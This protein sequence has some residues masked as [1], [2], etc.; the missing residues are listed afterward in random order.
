MIKEE[1]LLLSKMSYTSKDF[2]A[3]YTDLLD[4]A[5]QLT[6]KWDPSLSNESDPGVV[7]LKEG[8]FIADHG[9]YNIDKNVLE[10][11]L[12]SATQDTSA[13]NILE[14]NGYTPEYYISASG[15]VNLTYQ[16][17]TI[18]EN[19][20]GFT[21][22][23]FT[24]VITNAD[25]SIF[26]TQV[27]SI[28]IS[29]IGLASTA[30]FMQG[31]KQSLAINGS[32]TI[33]L[34]NLD[35]NNRVYLPVKQ[36]AE[37]GIFIKNVVTTAQDDGE[38][39]VKN[40]YISTQPLNSKVY[41]VGYDSA[42]GVPYIEFPSDI[43]NIIGS[44]LTID[45]IT[46]DGD[47]GN[48]KANT[49]IQI[50]SPTTLTIEETGLEID[51]TKDFN[52]TN[53]TSIMNGKNPETINEM[54]R[55]FK[56]V[57]GTFD[58]LVTCKDYSNAIFN[59]TESNSTNK[60]VS[61]DVVTDRNS[62]FNN[63]F[64]IVTY[65]QYGEYFETVSK[66]LNTPGF[67]LKY[68][69]PEDPNIG[70]ISFE[71]PNFIMCV[72]NSIPGAPIWAKVV[73]LG[74]KDF[75]NTVEAMTP[76]DLGLYCL[77]AFS[78][79][80]YI[81]ST[82][83]KAIEKSFE[84]IIDETQLGKI[85]QF[86]GANKCINHD[87]IET[88]SND[89]ICFKNYVPLNITITP[90]SKVTKQE[91]EEIIDNIYKSLSDNF[92]ASKVDFGDELSYDEVLQVL[93]NCDDRIKNIRLEDFEYNPKAMLRD[94]IETSGYREVPLYS[95][96][97][98]EGSNILL[99]VIAK[100]VLAGRLCL[101]DFD[102]EFVIK[103]GQI[104]TKKYED[105]ASIEAK[106]EI[107][108]DENVDVS[109]SNSS[110]INTT[111]NYMYRDIHTNISING[112]EENVT[113]T[114]TIVS[115]GSYQLKSTEIL[116]IDT[117]GVVKEYYSDEAE[118]ELIIENHTSKD[119]TITYTGTEPKM[120][121]ELQDGYISLLSQYEVNDAETYDLIYKPKENE[122]IEIAYNNYSTDATFPTYVKYS[123]VAYGVDEGYY[124]PANTDHKLD[125]NETLVLYYTENDIASSKTYGTNEVIRANFDL[126]P[127]SFGSTVGLT[128]T[129]N[130]ESGNVVTKILSASQQIEHRQL[131]LTQ[132]TSTNVPCYWLVNNNSNTLFFNSDGTHTRTNEKILSSG[133]YFIYSNS[134]KDSMVILG[135]G[136]LLNRSENDT[137]SWS[138]PDRITFKDIEENGFNA[139]IEWQTKDFSGNNKLSY[140][141]M[142]IITLASGDELKI[143]DWYSTTEEVVI[144]SNWVICD[145]NIAYDLSS[146][147]SVKLSEL[148]TGENYRIRSRLDLNLDNA[149]GQILKE[150]QSF[151]IRYKDS[152]STVTIKGSDTNPIY[153]QSSAEL[154]LYGDS[155]I[156]ISDY[157]SGNSV[158][159]FNEYKLEKPTLHTKNYEP[160][161]EGLIERRDNLY[162]R[163]RNNK[164]EVIL[165]SEIDALYETG[166]T[167]FSELYVVYPD[168]LWYMD[169]GYVHSTLEQTND[170][171]SF[172]IYNPGYAEF[173]L[174]YDCT[175]GLSD[176]HRE[177][178]LPIFLNY[179]GSNIKAK[180][181]D[182]NEEYTIYI[183]DYNERDSEGEEIDPVPVYTLDNTEM[184]LLRVCVQG[185]SFPENEPIKTIKTDI[186]L[187]IEWDTIPE[188]PEIIN[189]LD[190]NIIN[191][192][193]QGFGFDITL[194]RM[195]DKIGELIKNSTK[196]NTKPYYIY[197]PED[198]I[199]IQDP[200]FENPNIF[201]DKNNIINNL[202]IPQV[203]IRTMADKN[204]PTIDIIKSMRNY[205]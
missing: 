72:D 183:Q 41:K 2:P 154:N 181:K 88:K 80:D 82:P 126:Y 131:M 149:T 167:N 48:T 121:V 164:Y 120:W 9:N 145:G 83:Y 43:A 198:S 63:S 96:S 135:P 180:L 6:D 59:A 52:I 27:S 81:S 203:D 25:N 23:E 28:S 159:D 70:D 53:T 117:K 199:A 188:E 166:I 90:Y 105:V 189:I 57:V 124:I 204:Y 132:L 202:I 142:N 173:K 130:Y 78:L 17:E 98:S 36:V 108:A 42:Q 114:V 194:E 101:F 182:I 97:G 93:L 95:V 35:D 200:D 143:K 20:N 185:L 33:L 133:E 113:Q 5:K 160:Q 158:L 115:G 178:I 30:T 45:Y 67:S 177:Y 86:I 50:S 184:Y 109:Y 85:K 156:N 187:T 138:I 84:P 192:P 196:P 205:K 7:L 129:T 190:P 179:G 65:D 162:Y 73:H 140:Q 111:I 71:N 87:F 21:I 24:L 10:N 31:T 37:N 144:T 49:L 1:D 186:K 47:Y 107:K 127:T 119:I 58:T 64:K 69:K 191:G 123:F 139:D 195:L 91:K 38:Y 169:K 152:E 151:I 137:S 165:K 15:I 110:T 51:V 112:T 141:E 68:P 62:D 175:F 146:G 136:T 77:K 102:D 153:L 103:Y 92:N 171:Y 32:N 94:T 54:Y 170:K 161:Y 26:Y 4:L 155:E 75:M 172:N 13:R 12:P 106:V 39:W 46:T 116:Y 8:A 168:T 104:E 176:E 14:M 66:L 34:E 134:N 19:F 125:S 89:V 3:I 157:T 40:N 201:W 193:N 56:K 61:N 99:E 148:P 128:K 74:Y 11:F 163:V 18:P 22:P 118:H 55:A 197:K 100:N 79:S 16:P 44:G 150:G 60:L 147:E 122:Y 76:Y 174:G 29:K